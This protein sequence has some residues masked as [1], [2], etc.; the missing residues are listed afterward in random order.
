MRV[1]T[2]NFMKN[3]FKYFEAAY[4][5]MATAVIDCFILYRQNFWSNQNIFFLQEKGK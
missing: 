5:K 4:F 1:T 3:Y 2:T